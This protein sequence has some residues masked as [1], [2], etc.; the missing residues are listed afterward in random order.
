MHRFLLA[1]PLLALAACNGDANI[2]ID[3]ENVSIHTS[4][5]SLSEDNFDMNGIELYPGSKVG[6]FRLDARDRKDAPDSGHVAIQ[7]ESPAGIDKVQAWF[8]DAL[9]KRGY[10]LAA[11]GNGFTGTNGEG[12]TVALDLTAQ[13]A[14]KT[15]GRLEVGE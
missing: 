11:K 13:G 8:R 1:A 7:F 6:D 10:T 3:G 5:M 9:T 14:D 2:S 15:K 12:D 4:N